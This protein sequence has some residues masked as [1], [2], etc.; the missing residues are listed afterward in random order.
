MKSRVSN[1]KK[2]TR[3]RKTVG[4]I[5]ASKLLASARQRAK[6]KKL[7]YALAPH[8]AQIARRVCR[9]KCELSGLPFVFSGGPMAPSIDRIC[10]VSTVVWDKS[11][12]LANTRIILWCLNAS[13]GDWGQG[14][15]MNVMA[16]A[17]RT[18][19]TLWRP[20]PIPVVDAPTSV[21]K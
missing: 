20:M 7:H 12:T 14:V 13:F 21:R 8:A 19:A 17:Q 10:C 3:R 11:Y 4:E 1:R 6:K 2:Q 15:M 18:Q 16:E 9:G 5:V